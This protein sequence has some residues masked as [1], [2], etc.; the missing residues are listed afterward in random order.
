MLP[1]RYNKKNLSK[2]VTR[3]FFGVDSRRGKGF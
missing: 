1:D 2:F 3:S